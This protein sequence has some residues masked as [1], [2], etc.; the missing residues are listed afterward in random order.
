MK[1]IFFNQKYCHR[2]RQQDTF[3]YW[4]KLVEASTPLKKRVDNIALSKSLSSPFMRVVSK[5]LQ[6]FPIINIRK[7]KYFP[8]DIDLIY[9]WWDIPLNSDKSY[10]IELD[11]PYLLTLYNSFALGLYKP[12]IRYLLKKDNCKKIICISEACQKSFLSLL[13]KDLIYKTKVLYPRMIDNLNNENNSWL[14]KFVFVWFD[15]IRKWVIEL[16]E[17]F[18]S[19]NDKNIELLVIWFNNY[20]L[21][22][23]YQHDIRI[24]FLWK[25][26]REK[27]INEI[28]K[29]SDIFIFPTLHESFW[30][31]ALEA[32]SCSMWII[33]TNIYA[34]PELVIN[35]KNW[36]IINHPYF[37]ENKLWFVDVTNIDINK[38]NDIY[39]KEY[40]F[41]KKFFNDIKNAIK[42]WIKNHNEWK[43]SSS[44]LY[45]EKF[46]EKKWEESFLD[47]INN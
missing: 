22:N 17:A 24:K 13:W 9:T 38:F 43:I 41:N 44:A 2:E 31:A 5:I 23:K 18:S 12:I 25:L 1:K 7:I 47:I 37:N 35:N 32:L 28:Y 11:N 21:E 10:I 40:K 29:K 45:L 19:I 30:I 39:L 3:K 36:I 20:K 6:I 34:L 46:S 26:Q 4:S 15:P 27:I 16:L 33:T 8:N 42:M 14:I